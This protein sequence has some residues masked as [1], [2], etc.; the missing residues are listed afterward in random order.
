MVTDLVTRE[1]SLD[2]PVSSGEIKLDVGNDLIKVAAIDRVKSPGKTFTGLIKGFGMHA[3][4]MA[5]SA[6]WDTTCII[7]VG[8]DENDMAMCLNRIR[9]LSGGAV[10][11]RGGKVMAELPLPIFGIMT[12]L[13]IAQLDE[14]IIAVKK[15]GTLN[16]GSIPDPLLT[17]VTLTGAA[18]PYFRICEEG[19]VNLKDGETKGLFVF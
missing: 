4:A 16:G 10:F 2:L 18:I 13:P 14:K 7:V 6:A 3:G 17:I 12:D 11:C 15:G 9:D 19:L 5:S 1:V 8:A